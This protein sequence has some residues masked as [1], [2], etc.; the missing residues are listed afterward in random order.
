M[1]LICQ[2]LWHIKKAIDS[3]QCILIQTKAGMGGT[4]APTPAK[5]FIATLL[6]ENLLIIYNI[7]SSPLY[8]SE[9]A[10]S[11]SFLLSVFLS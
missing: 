6:F 11:D 1:D 10:S 9:V 3:Q 7:H 2:E 8:L 4:F 5:D